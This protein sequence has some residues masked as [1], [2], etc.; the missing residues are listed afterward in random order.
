[1]DAT[2]PAV[3]V[4]DD[5]HALRTRGPDGEVD[6]GRGADDPPV[7]TELLERAVEGALT[8]EMQIEV[9]QHLPIPVGIVYLE[10]VS[11]DE[12]DPES[13]VGNLGPR[14]EGEDELEEPRLVAPGHRPPH[15][16]D[17]HLDQARR[18]LHR[19]NGEAL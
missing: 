5:A 19:A 16:A 10:H 11:I 18:R 17:A 3:E 4:A 15:L 13:V 2:V 6:A 14:G 9:A 12:R 7:R 8:E 1:M